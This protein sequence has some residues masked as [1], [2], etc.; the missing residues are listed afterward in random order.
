MHVITKLIDPV[1]PIQKH[2][3]LSRCRTLLTTAECLLNENRNP[4]KSKEEIEQNLKDCLG[5]SKIIW[6][7]KGLYKGLYEAHMQ[8]LCGRAISTPPIRGH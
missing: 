8:A 4:G 1:I 3:W 7:D 6:L 2:V 5:V